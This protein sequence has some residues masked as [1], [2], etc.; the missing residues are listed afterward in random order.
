[1]ND[2]SHGKQAMDRMTFPI[3]V[4]LGT[5]AGDRLQ[6]RRRVL[7]TGF[8][9]LFV[10][11]PVMDIF[12]ID[13]HAKHLVFFGMDWTLGLDAWMAGQ[14]SAGAAM[15]NLLL[16]GLLPIVLVVGVF[17]WTAWKYGRLYCGWLCPHFSVV[18]TINGILRRAWGR[19]SLWERRPLPDVG[20]SGRKL[21]RHWLYWPLFGL[22]VGGFAFLWAVVLLTYL[23]PPAEI[24]ANLWTGELTANQ[25]I[26]LIAAT[27]VL[28]IEFAF[29]R[30]LFCR[31]GCAVGVFQSFVW[32]ANKRAMVV[33]FDRQRAAACRTCDAQCEHACPMRLKPRDIK[34]HMFT[35]TECARCLQACE[36]VQAGGAG[37]SGVIQAPLLQWVQD[38]CALDVSERDFGHKPEV[39]R[40]CFRTEG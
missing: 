21:S 37:N 2:C 22:A 34:R 25:T 31:F 36:Q 16:R 10:L 27:I 1:M 30:H 23:L 26:F 3:P 5:Q 8:F 4:T 40:N 29:A 38:A 35:C 17:A 24:Y 28:I 20:A 6:R 32:M 13:L 15:L 19:P 14:A 12:R 18:E 7:Q 39:N 11:A 9:V 33:G